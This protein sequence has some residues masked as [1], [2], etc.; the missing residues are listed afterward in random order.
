LMIALR[1]LINLGLRALGRFFGKF[2]EI[3]DIYGFSLYFGRFGWLC[4]W[5]YGLY[6][7]CGGCPH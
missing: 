1:S 7:P 2:Q 4:G 6:L 5:L 3:L